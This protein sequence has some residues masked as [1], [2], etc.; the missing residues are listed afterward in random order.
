MSKQAE[1]LPELLPTPFSARAT[2]TLGAIML[3]LY[4]VAVVAQAS[5]VF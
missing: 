1:K 2:V 5:N 3:A 4:A